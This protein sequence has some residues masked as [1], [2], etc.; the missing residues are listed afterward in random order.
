MFRPYIFVFQRRRNYV[1]VDI[2]NYSL[3]P[4]RSLESPV[5]AKS[6]RVIVPGASKNVDTLRGVD[7]DNTNKRLP[8]PAKRERDLENEEHLISG[9]GGCH[10]LPRN[11]CI[12]E[13]IAVIF[14][15]HVTQNS[16]AFHW[17]WFTL[18]LT[19]YSTIIE[20]GISQWAENHG[21]FQRYY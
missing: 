21:I 20:F 17:H 14:W 18:C 2:F 12:F 10:A 7:E 9:C 5:V 15:R 4:S 16:P 11:Q 6:W 1:A 19:T 3:I 8:G 13:N